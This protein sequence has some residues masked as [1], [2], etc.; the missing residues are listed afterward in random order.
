MVH[1]F[2]LVTEHLWKT[3]E[4][5]FSDRVDI[6]LKKS[7]RKI[8]IFR[9]VTDFFKSA[10]FC[11]HICRHTFNMTSQPHEAIHVPHFAAE[12]KELQLYPSNSS[13]IKS[14]KVAI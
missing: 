4:M 5:K 11:H 13:E 12:F 8:L 14:R 9:K 2:F 6:V 10:F 7:H 1:N 3:P